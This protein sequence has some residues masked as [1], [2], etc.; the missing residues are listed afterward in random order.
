MTPSLRGDKQFVRKG[1]NQ[2]TLQPIRCIDTVILYTFLGWVSKGPK[3][4]EDENI[5]S[6]VR[7]I[8]ECLDDNCCKIF[9]CHD[10]VHGILEKDTWIRVSK[11]GHR[12]GQRVNCIQGQPTQYSFRLTVSLNSSNA[13]LGM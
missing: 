11:L 5:K 10:L 6:H 2:H 3:D 7:H 12:P 9:I 8:A 4:D 13:Q 1:I